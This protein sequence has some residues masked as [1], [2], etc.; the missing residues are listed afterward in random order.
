MA[1]SISCERCGNEL[2]IPGALLF[3]PPNTDPDTMES[4]GEV[5]KYH[6]CIFCW[7]KLFAGDGSFK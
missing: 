2:K 6:F 1:L 3:S 7:D 5:C 4:D